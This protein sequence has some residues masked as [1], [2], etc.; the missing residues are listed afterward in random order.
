[1]AADKHRFI[2]ETI[3]YLWGQ[4]WLL[5]NC[6]S[7]YS[8][9]VCGN[10]EHLDNFQNKSVNS[11]FRSVSRY[12]LFLPKLNGKESPLLEGEHIVKLSPRVLGWY[13][14]WKSLSFC[15]VWNIWG[16]IWNIFEEYDAVT[17][18]MLYLK[19]LHDM[20][21]QSSEINF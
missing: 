2:L 3:S 5:R 11:S 20:V 7:S 8:Y 21:S 19:V 6:S 9:S 13:N 14:R 10:R 12:I 16:N 15:G 18:T 17:F 4:C 1:M